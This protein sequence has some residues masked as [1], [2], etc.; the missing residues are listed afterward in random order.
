MWTRKLMVPCMYSL[1]F[2]Q[3]EPRRLVQWENIKTTIEQEGDLCKMSGV[4]QRHD[5]NTYTT[6][7]AIM[8]YT[9]PVISFV[10]WTFLD[11]DWIKFHKRLFVNKWKWHTS[12]IHRAQ[13]VH[14]SISMV[15]VNTFSAIRQVSIM[16]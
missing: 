9:I 10:P 5:D 8:E 2:P 14:E 11:I 3:G 13:F 7:I 1:F 4:S 6:T 16:N 15:C 12:L